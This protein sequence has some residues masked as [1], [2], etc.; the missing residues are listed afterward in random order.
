MLS[1]FWVCDISLITVSCIFAHITV[2]D[3]IFFSHQWLNIKMCTSTIVPL[4]IHQL[5]NTKPNSMSCLMLK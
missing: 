2:S 1:V 3:W 5:M 4:S